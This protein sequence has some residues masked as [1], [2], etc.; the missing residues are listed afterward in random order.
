MAYT[1][2]C[3]RLM[4][5]PSLS[6]EVLTGEIRSLDHTP[7]PA[8]PP[9]DSILMP[10]LGEKT[11]TLL[12][13]NPKDKIQLVIYTKIPAKETKAFPGKKLYSFQCIQLFKFSTTLG[14]VL[15]GSIF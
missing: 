12:P 4:V 9:L 8:V 5:F 15:L 10:R 7:E 6:G 14:Y 3:S 1:S 11:P 13:I 2:P